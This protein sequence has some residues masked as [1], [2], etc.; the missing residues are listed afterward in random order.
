MSYFSDAKGVDVLQDWD[1]F[2]ANKLTDYYTVK[3]EVIG[4]WFTFESGVVTAEDTTKQ[5]AVKQAVKDSKLTMA[6]FGSKKPIIVVGVVTGPGIKGNPYNLTEKKVYI[7]DVFN[8]DKGMYYTD[9]ELI[10]FAQTISINPYG[11]TFAAG[12]IIGVADF[13]TAVQAIKDLSEGE[14]TD[15]VEEAVLSSLNLLL[16]VDSA[17][18]PS[19]NRQGLLF[20]GLFGYTFNY[21]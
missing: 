19:L 8:K 1:N 21:R 18:N 6:L 14:G 13:K 9:Q 3:E 2:F 11:K 17:I 15:S 5:A 12:P 16:E 7:V 10:G 20:E 4:E